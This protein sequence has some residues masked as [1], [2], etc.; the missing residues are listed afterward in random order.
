MGSEPMIWVVLQI[1]VPFRVTLYE[2][3]VYN[4]DPTRD[5]NLENYPFRALGLGLSLGSLRSSSVFVG[6]G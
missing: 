5:P 2:G 4:G 3:A 1:R 6:V